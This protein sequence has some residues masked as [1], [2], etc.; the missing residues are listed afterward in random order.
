VSVLQASEEGRGPRAA[1]RRS[2]GVPQ[3]AF[4]IGTVARLVPVK[5][6][7]VML[8]AL[9]CLDEDMHLV[10]IGE[11][12]SRRALEELAQELHTFTD[13]YTSRGSWSRRRTCISSST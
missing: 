1:R 4:L 5:N 8:R 9:Q 12:P 10:L 13:V 6:H 2:W 3:G 11:G 7:A